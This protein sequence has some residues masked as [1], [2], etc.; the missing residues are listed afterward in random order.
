MHIE[1]A[2]VGV[3]VGVAG[4]SRLEIKIYRLLIILRN[5]VAIFVQT[6]EG[7]K[8]RGKPDVRGFLIPAYR[9]FVIDRRAFSGFVGVR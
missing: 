6:P 4:F 2:E 8:R 9:F 1:R 7:M 5:T 3:A